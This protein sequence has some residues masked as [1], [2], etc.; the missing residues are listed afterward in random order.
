MSNINPNNING[1]YPVAGVDNDSQGFRDNFT[2]IKN[3][4]TYAQA[5]INDLQGKAILKSAL[6]GSTLDNNM[7][8]AVLSSAS[9]RDFREI[10]QDNGIVPTTVTLDHSVA[11]HQTVQT[12]GTVTIAF[13]N[14]PK[15]GYI[16]RIRLKL[17]VTNSSHRLVLPTL[18]NSSYTNNGWVG[19]PYILEY[20]S[21][22]NSIGFTQS[23][24]GTY[25]FEFI[26]DD[27][28]NTFM[29]SDLTRNGLASDYTYA[30]ISANNYSTTVQNKLI[31]DTTLAGLS[32]IYVYL[33]N[34]P[35]DGQFVTISSMQTIYSNLYLI[36]NATAGTTILGNVSSL[37]G[38]SHIG[39]TY[40][41]NSAATVNKW[42]RTQA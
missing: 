33:P 6:T 30:N 27:G 32:N 19:T 8:G 2:N 3:N 1:A 21:S 4:F 37:T 5:E 31:L 7:T 34:V 29:I 38:N 42:F 14:L 28:G 15:A 26:T 10:R 16:G 40:V 24:A 20:N 18:S 11:H 25:Y 39:F 23:G 9:I 13:S 12:N 41:G 36:A 35:V 17:V 22:T